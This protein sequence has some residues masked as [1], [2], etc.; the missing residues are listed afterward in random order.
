[1][2]WS[3]LGRSVVVVCCVL[4]FVFFS[5]VLEF[6]GFDG[7][8]VLDFNEEFWNKLVWSY[9]IFMR[10]IFLFIEFFI[11]IEVGLIL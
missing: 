9:F 8:D 4:L 7:S 10:R 1:M 11:Y 2:I 3:C 5:V 6:V